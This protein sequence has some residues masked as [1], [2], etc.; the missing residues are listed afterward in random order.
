MTSQQLAD[1]LLLKWQELWPLPASERGQRINEIADE[2]QYDDLLAS[3]S[4]AL[5]LEQAA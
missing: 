3:M 2:I 5:N 1:C 4:V